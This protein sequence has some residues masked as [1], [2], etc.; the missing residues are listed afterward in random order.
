[1]WV[2]INAS[3]CT[4]NWIRKQ[5]HKKQNVREFRGNPLSI[6]ANKLLFPITR[7]HHI[8]IYKLFNLI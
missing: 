5:Q 4:I 7:I 8:R 3:A 6:D 1:M 2:D